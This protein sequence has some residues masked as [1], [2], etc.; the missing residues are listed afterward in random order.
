MII[1]WSPSGSKEHTHG[2]E[3]GENLMKRQ[4]REEWAESKTKKVWPTSRD[5]SNFSPF[6]SETR[7]WKYSWHLGRGCPARHSAK[8]ASSPSWKYALC[9]FVH[10]QQ[11]WAGKGCMCICGQMGGGR[12]KGGLGPLPLLQLGHIY[13]LCYKL[14]FLI[15]TIK[16][17]TLWTTDCV[18]CVT[19]KYKA[20]KKWSLLWVY[21]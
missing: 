20:I 8:T 17:K 12:W 5:K 13:R 14:Q 18:W 16:K 10:L 15:R 4:F 1:K 19:R 3:L 11:E 21:N 2:I 6:W 9:S 7:G